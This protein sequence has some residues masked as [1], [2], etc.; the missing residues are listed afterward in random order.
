MIG[1]SLRMVVGV[2]TLFRR[3]ENAAA[4]VAS[5]TYIPFADISHRN[6]AW[7]DRSVSSSP[8]LRSL[9]S[10]LLL[11]LNPLAAARSTTSLHRFKKGGPSEPRSSTPRAGFSSILSG[12]VR[13]KRSEAGRSARSSS[14]VAASHGTEGHHRRLRDA[15]HRPTM[16]RIRVELRPAADL[17]R[18]CR[19]DRRSR[20]GSDDLPR[21]PG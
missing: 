19:R 16:L 17:R 11:S 3:C 12:S 15:S 20:P 14:L 5:R 18:Q 1:R 4:A 9:E 7:T 21:P 10:R 8:P 13:T 6:I 2:Y